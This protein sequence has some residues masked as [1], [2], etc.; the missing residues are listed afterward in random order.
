MSKKLEEIQKRHTLIKSLIA[1]QEILNQTQLQKILKRNG[2]EVT[3]ATLSR[4]L[5]EL[6]I[7]RVP[8]S[9]GIVYK[10][11]P[12]GDEAALKIHIAEEIISIECNE[13]LIVLKTYPGR[14]Q[15]VAALLDKQNSTECIGTLA[16]DDTIIIIPRSI[17]TIKKTIEQI[18]TILGI[19]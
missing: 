18:K 15:G 8:S 9:N 10:I 3:Q 17:K 6:G 1:S 19:R 11:N 14:A 12:T 7:A 16:G 2:V 13:A 4:D 5:A